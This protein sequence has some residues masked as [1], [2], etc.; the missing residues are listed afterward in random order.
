[1]VAAVDSAPAAVKAVMVP[2]MEL[3]AKMAANNKLR[4]LKA[5][6]KPKLPPAMLYKNPK[7]HLL[8]VQEKQKTL[9]I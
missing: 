8:T 9:L 3:K 1:M 4:Q 2:A 7:K 6:A 5:P